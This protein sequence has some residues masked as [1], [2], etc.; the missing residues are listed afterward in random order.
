MKR[1]LAAAALLAATTTANAQIIIDKA[2][3]FAYAQSPTQIIA[4]SHEQCADSQDPNVK[5]A[6]YWFRVGFAAGIKKDACW[7]EKNDIENAITYCEVWRDSNDKRFLNLCSPVMRTSLI[8]VES[9]PEQANLN[10]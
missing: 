5:M 2:I 6:S 9:L 4:L 7:S 8:S 1:L 10:P 3:Y